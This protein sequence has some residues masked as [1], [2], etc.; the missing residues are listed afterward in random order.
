MRLVEEVMTP[1]L[2][3]HCKGLDAVTNY[4][5][6]TFNC[7]AEARARRL[8]NFDQAIRPSRPKDDDSMSVED[9]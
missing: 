6:R 2:R 8:A 3:E 9:L 5:N 7:F 4:V 1:E